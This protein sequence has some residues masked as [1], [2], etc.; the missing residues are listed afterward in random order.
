MIDTPEGMAFVRA[1]ARKGALSMEIA[2]LRRRGRSAY[3]IV[4][5]VYGFSGSRES[6]L[7]DLTEYV[8]A[9]LRLRE[10][11]KERGEELTRIGQERI[12]ILEQ[13][14]PITQMAFESDLA[15]FEETGRID[16]ETRQALSDLFYVAI[17]RQNAGGR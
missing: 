7:A 17:V 14:S 5:E 12:A 1:A 6:V 2:G 8:E 13:E 15:F 4:K 9:E 16:A 3:S 10:I 11:P